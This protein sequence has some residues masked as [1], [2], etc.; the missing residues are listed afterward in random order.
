M[1]ALVALACD[2]LDIDQDDVIKGRLTADSV[3][4]IVRQGHKY[5]VPRSELVIPEPEIPEP[6]I[7]EPVEIIATTEARAYAKMHGVD[8]STV[9]GTG[10]GGRIL[11]RDVKEAING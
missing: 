8:L 2:L 10:R 11:V 9:K 5:V 4:V 3:V 1:D 6:T 7:P